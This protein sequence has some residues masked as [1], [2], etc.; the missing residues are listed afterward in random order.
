MDKVVVVSAAETVAAHK[1]EDLG[2]ICRRNVGVNAR[3]GRRNRI[4]ANRVAWENR[5]EYSSNQHK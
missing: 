5:G 4:P 1:L 2:K 3:I